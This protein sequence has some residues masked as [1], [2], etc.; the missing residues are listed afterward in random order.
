MGEVRQV[1]AEEEPNIKE[2]ETNLENPDEKNDHC[3][4]GSQ[5]RN[6]SLLLEVLKYK[7]S[8]HL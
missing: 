5:T 4:S 2:T 3:T 6:T 8:N 7:F 1:K